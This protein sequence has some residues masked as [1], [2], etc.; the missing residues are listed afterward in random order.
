MMVKYKQRQHNRRVR[1]RLGKRKI[2]VNRGVKR[3]VF[4]RERAIVRQFQL[5]GPKPVSYSDFDRF[6]DEVADLK[7]LSSSSDPEISIPNSAR[8]ESL[9]SRSPSRFRQAE[10]ALFEDSLVRQSSRFGGLMKRSRDPFEVTKDLYKSVER[11]D[12]PK[13][14]SFRFIS[15]FR[16]EESGVSPEVAE[17]IQARYLSGKSGYRGRF[18]GYD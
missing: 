12:V 8:L 2:T 4:G 6:K 3:A 15:D 16:P 5:G 14:E 17:R 11:K 10:V 1:T 18:H 9:R 13:V 7:F